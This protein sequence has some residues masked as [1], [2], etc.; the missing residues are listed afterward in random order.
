[1]TASI[2]VTGGTGTL[3]RHVVRRLREAGREVRV[4]S[5][6]RREHED[7]V[8][9][10]TGDLATGAGLAD[11]LVGVG[12][13]VHLAGEA[14]GDEDKAR[15]LVAAALA[16]PKEPHIVYIS[17]VG[18][19][20]IPL[21]GRM[22]RAMFSYFGAKL[23]AERIIAGSGLPYSIL[24]ATQFHDLLYKVAEGMAKLPVIPAPGFRF[25]PIEADEVAAGL[26]ELA[27]GE[28]AGRVPDM[29]GPRVYELR[30]LI[31]SYVRATGRRRLIV[32]ERFPGKAARAF[33][34]GANLNPGRAVGR[35]SWEEFLIER[36][37]ARSASA[38]RSP[39]TT[40]IRQ[41]DGG[42]VRSESTR[43]A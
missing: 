30:D 22:D 11:A 10:V 12:T 24:R 27:L 13:V 37:G 33:R 8:R 23:A 15:H 41:G 5:R 6:R 26:V 29:G 16:Q 7:G 43:A 34:D 18:A 20:R 17:V 39:S 42:P 28:P 1:M 31:R 38:D 2:L 21:D 9:Y 40:S 4:L 32:P 19:D 35:R 3:G 36:V 25:Q 14:K